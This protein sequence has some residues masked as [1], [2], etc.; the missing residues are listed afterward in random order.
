[1]SGR[2]EEKVSL[3]K[4]DP[5]FKKI[6]DEEEREAQIP[7]KPDT[8]L[9]RKMKRIFGGANDAK[10]MFLY[11]FKFGAMVGGSFGG[12]FGT[13]Y[14]IKHRQFMYIPIAMLSS[15]CSFGFFMGLGFIL[16]N[17]MLSY[18]PTQINMVK[19]FSNN[20][21]LPVFSFKPMFDSRELE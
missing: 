17:Q 12:V 2:K 1:M 14:A 13:F 18:A 11:G 19:T 9:V 8:F 16:R 5:Q 21:E 20:G 6:F 3:D 15:G 7:R 4:F 10:K